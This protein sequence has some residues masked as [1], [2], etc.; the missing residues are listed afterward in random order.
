MIQL[1]KCLHCKK[2]ISF[3]YPTIE[4]LTG[5]LFAYSYATI[6]MQLEFI[7][8]LLLTSILMIILVTDI[9]YMLIPNKILIFFYP[10]FIIMR[11]VQPLD[12][13]WSAPLGSI[14][15][16]LLIMAIIFISRGGIGA[17]DMKLFGVLGI[18]LGL[19][20]VLLTFFL[21]CIIGSFIGFMLL[22]FKLITRK[23]AVPFGPYIIAATFFSY[24]YGDQ[25][26]SWYYSLF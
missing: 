25:I 24:F 14:V 9:T 13:W 18:V 3:I 26:T 15:G 21:S 12:P 19:E 16:F 11:I 7:T 20:K 8:S 2:R 22:A 17:G 4:L 6:G 1:A 23:Q 5:I 10:F